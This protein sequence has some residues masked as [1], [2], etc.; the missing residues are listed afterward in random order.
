MKNKNKILVMTYNFPPW[1]GGDSIR[2]RKM[3]KY[4]LRMGWEVHVLTIDE[5]YIDPDAP[6]D[7][8]TMDEVKDCI[9]HRTKSL[10]PSSEKKESIRNASGIARD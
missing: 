5:S 1:G 6:R 8:L 4:F 7:T 2:V 10:E 3:V 9:I